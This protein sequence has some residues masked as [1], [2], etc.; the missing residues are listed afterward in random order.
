MEEKE[1]VGAPE[2]EVE[3]R[4]E[5]APGAW[6]PGSLRVKGTATLNE[7][8][9]VDGELST[10]GECRWHPSARAGGLRVDGPFRVGDATIADGLVARRGAEP[11]G[12]AP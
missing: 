8:A 4:F 7:G 3:G 10:T 2:S 6:L 12:V 5:M 11:M 1:T 9:R